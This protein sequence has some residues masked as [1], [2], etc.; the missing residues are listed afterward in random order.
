MFSAAVLAGCGEKEE[1]SQS[2]RHSRNSRDDDEDDEDDEDEDDG[3]VAEDEDAGSTGGSVTVCDDGCIIVSDVEGLV[4]AMAPGAHIVL[5]PGVYNISDYLNSLDGADQVAQFDSASITDSGDVWMTGVYDGLQLECSN[6]EGL[7]I[8]GRSSDCADTQIITDPRYANVFTFHFSDNL[9]LANLTIGHTDT[10]ECAGDVLCFEGC[11][12]AVFVNCDMF[13]CGCFGI[14]TYA[15]VDANT[16]GFH[17]YDCT[18]RDCSYGPLN[19]NGNDDGADWTFA[20]CAL[21][22]SRGGGSIDMLGDSKMY[23]YDC[24]FGD[25]E[26]AYFFNNSRAVKEN[27]EYG[28]IEIYPEYP[29]DI[30]PEFHTDRIKVAP[31]DAG[32]LCGTAWRWLIPVDDETTMAVPEWLCFADDGSGIWEKPYAEPEFTWECDSQYSAVLYDEYGNEMGSVTLYYDPEM[33]DIMYMYG[34][35]YDEE[36]WFYLD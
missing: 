10:G 5:E 20:R 28:E 18:I 9:M 21:T 13:G 27:C 17:L 30:G 14:T 25:Q 11:A 32:V 34:E 12:D 3:D 29:S 26:L 6:L 16:G 22:G 8:I 7:S 36:Y 23:F 35:L 15:A 1:E 4:A 33:E 19:I 31:F 2:S 24:V